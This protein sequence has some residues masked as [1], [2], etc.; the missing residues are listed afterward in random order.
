MSARDILNIKQDTRKVKDKLLELLQR[1]EQEGQQKLTREDP[2]MQLQRNYAQAAELENYRRAQASAAK[3]VGQAMEEL[4][5]NPLYMN[6]LRDIQQKRN[7]RIAREYGNDLGMQQAAQGAVRAA[8]PVLGD[9]RRQHAEDIINR[10]ATWKSQISGT[11]QPPRGSTMT[12]AEQ[13]EAKR[14]AQ[15]IADKTGMTPWFQDPEN[16]TEAEMKAYSLASTAATSDW[17]RNHP[18]AGKARGAA[19]RLDNDLAAENAFRTVKGK[20]QTLQDRQDQDEFEADQAF[21]WWMQ[22]EDGQRMLPY[23]GG[24]EA[25]LRQAYNAD[26]HQAGAGQGIKT[27]AV[28]MWKKALQEQKRQEKAAATAKVGGSP[29]VEWTNT[30]EGQALAGEYRQRVQDYSADMLMEAWDYLDP[31]DRESYYAYIH[32]GQPRDLSLVLGEDYHEMKDEEAAAFREELVDASLMRDF[33]DKYGRNGD[34]YYA[35]RENQE[36]GDR[37]AQE[38]IGK[39]QGYGAQVMNQVY[40]TSAENPLG[41]W[42]LWNQEFERVE[43]NLAE[44][45]TMKAAGAYADDPYYSVNWNEN[46][47]DQITILENVQALM[48][49]S[50]VVMEPDFAMRSQPI[51]D[52]E[53]DSTYAMIAGWIQPPTEEEETVEDSDDWTYEDERSR[54]LT[55]KA[56]TMGDYVD[57]M[58]SGERSTYFYI[59]NTQGKEAALEY[60]YALENEMLYKS[61]SARRERE[62]QWAK[63]NPWLSSVTDILMTPARG[64]SAASYMIGNLASGGH[65]SPYHHSLDIADN[66]VQHRRA[67]DDLTWVQAG[68][69]AKGW[70]GDAFI[71]ANQAWRSMTGGPELTE[72]D[73]ARIREGIQQGLLDLKHGGDSGGD[74]A[75]TMAA[76]IGMGKLLGACMTG[77][78]CG[79]SAL[80]MTAEEFTRWTFSAGMQMSLWWQSAQA[81]ALSTANAKETG[82][83]DRVAAIRGIADFAA[84]HLTET[85]G[86]EGLARYGILNTALRGRGHFMAANFVLSCVAEG[87]E[88]VGSGLF[89]M[90]LDRALNRSAAEWDRDRWAYYQ[91]HQDE[92]I[93]LE[94]ADIAVGAKFAGE[95]ATEAIITAITTGPATAGNMMMNRIGIQQQAQQSVNNM[96]TQGLLT[97]SQVKSATQTL[98]R[99]MTAE[100]NI[101]MAQEEGIAP[102]AEDLE[103]LQARETLLGTI[104]DNQLDQLGSEAFAAMELE[105]A[106]ETGKTGT[107]AQTEAT[108][109][110]AEKGAED[111]E[112]AKIRQ[113]REENQEHLEKARKDLD[114]AQKK[115]DEAQNGQNSDMKTG[116][117][118]VLTNDTEE[119]IKADISRL[120]YQVRQFEQR[121]QML[122]QQEADLQKQGAE[123]GT[124]GFQPEGTRKQGADN[125]QQKAVRSRED[126]QQEM[127]QLQQGIEQAKAKQEEM[128]AIIATTEDESALS[129]A[130]DLMAEQQ[131]IEHAMQQ[132]Q[133]ELKEE[134]AQAEEAER[135]EAEEKETKEKETEKQQADTDIGQ[136]LHREARQELPKFTEEEVQNVYRILH[137]RQTK[138]EM[139]QDE[140]RELMEKWAEYRNAQGHMVLDARVK[141]DGHDAKVVGLESV[142]EDAQVIVEQDGERSTMALDDE[143]LKFS[144][145]WQRE[146]YQFA[147]GMKDLTA[148][149]LVLGA[150]EKSEAEFYTFQRAFSEVYDAARNGMQLNQAQKVLA[151]TLGA[152]LTN[153][154][155]QVGYETMQAE[156]QKLLGSKN[157]QDMRAYLRAMRNRDT[158]AEGYKGAVLGQT[159]QIDNL[160]ADQMISIQI[161]DTLAQNIGLRI[162]I[163][164]HIQTKA[165]QMKVEETE[166]KQVPVR[167]GV[168]NGE[169]IKGSN[170]MLVALDSMEGAIVNHA[171]HESWHWVRDQAKKQ[172]DK[173]LQAEVDAFGYQVLER[174]KKNDPAYNV[175]DRIRE[176]IEQYASMGVELTRGEAEEELQA[177]A[178]MALMNDITEMELMQEQ[179]P[180]ILKKI[181]DGLKYWARK[182]RD[183]IKGIGWDNTEVRTMLATEADQLEAMARK[184]YDLM[185]L[186]GQNQKLQPGKNARAYSLSNEAAQEPVMYSMAGVQAQGKFGEAA[187]MANEMARQGRTD[188]EIRKATGAIKGYRGRWWARIDNTDMR[189][190][191]DTLLRNAILRAVENNGMLGVAL[192]DLYEAEDLYQAYPQLRDTQVTFREMQE[193]ALAAV[194]FVNGRAYIEI[195]TEEIR[196]LEDQGENFATL[197]EESLQHEVQHIIQHYEGSNEGSNTVIW[198]RIRQA[199]R[200]TAEQMNRD[201]MTL[202]DAYGDDFMSDIHLTPRYRLDEGSYT[203]AELEEIQQTIPAE[204][205]QAWGDIRRF[206]DKY[207]RIMNEDA[208]TLYRNTVGEIEARSQE[209]RGSKLNPDY[210]NAVAVEDYV[211]LET[212]EVRYSVSDADYMDAVRRG[213]TLKAADMVAEAARRAGY[214]LRVFHQTKAEFNRFNTDNESAGQYDDETPT[215]LFFKTTPEDI[216]LDGKKQMGLFIRSSRMI[217]FANREEIRKYWDEHVPGYKELR[218]KMD[219]EDRRLEQEYKEIDARWD[220]YY[221]EHYDAFVANDPTVTTELHQITKELDA[222][223]EKWE[224]DLHPIR[225]QLKEMINSY[226]RTADFDGIHLAFDGKMPG[227]PAVETYIVFDPSQVKS[228][229]PVTYDDDGN[230]IP[231]SERFNPE[232]DDIRYSLAKGKTATREETERA[233]KI[234]QSAAARSTGMQVDA[235]TRSAYTDMRLSLTTL[236]K[237]EYVTNRNK[238][239]QMVMEATSRDLE[240]VSKWFDDV[241]GIASMIAADRTRLD[242]VGLRN[243]EGELVNS[244]LKSNP[245][246]GGSIDMSLI[247]AKRRL[248]TGTIDA[249]QRRLGDSGFLTAEEMMQVRNMLLKKGYQAACGLCFVE[250][251]RKNMG[252]LMNDFRNAY[253]EKHKGDGAF[254]PSMTDINTVDGLADLEI[255]HPDVYWELVAYMN[256]MAQRKPK[257]YEVRTEYNN[258]ILKRFS[259]DGTVEAKNLA[260]GLRINSFSDFEVVHL[261]D[262]MQVIMDMSAVGLA[263]QAYTKVPDFAWALGGTGL[264]INLSMIAKG[265][266]RDGKIIFDEVEGMKA[267]D[268]FDLR[269]EY[270]DNVGTILVVFTDAQLRAAVNDDRI[271]FIIPFHRSQWKKADYPN[272]GLAKDTR[273]YTMHQNERWLHPSRHLNANGNKTRP[274]NFMPNE[275]W[276]FSLSGKENAK[277]YLQKCAEEDRRPKF[278]K[279][280]VDNHNGTW[281]LPEDGSMDGYWKLLIDFKMYNNKGEGRRQMPVQ[282]IFNMEQCERMLRD[283]KGGHDTFPVADDVVD[284]FMAQREKER[285]KRKAAQE[286]ASYSL[287]SPVEYSL[288]GIDETDPGMAQL[289]SENERFRNLTAQLAAELNRQEQRSTAQLTSMANMNRLAR[290]LRDKWRVAL[291]I[292]TMAENLRKIFEGLSQARTVAQAQAAMQA[293]GDFARDAILN[294]QTTDRTAHDQYSEARGL[295]RRN[296]RADRATILDVFGDMSSY[297]KN[298]FGRVKLVNQGMNV[299]SLYT[300][301]RDNYPGTLPDGLVNEADQLRAMLD[302]L[303]ATDIR[304]YNPYEEGDEA[305]MGGTVEVVSREL[306]MRLL[307]MYAEGGKDA[308][309]NGMSTHRMDQINGLLDRAEVVVQDTNRTMTTAGYRG[310]TSREYNQRI[311]D[312]RRELQQRGEAVQQRNATILQLETELKEA[313]RQIRDG[314]STIQTLRTRLN[315]QQAALNSQQVEDLKNQIRQEEAKV[316]A[317]QRAAQALQNR[318]DRSRQTQELNKIKRE[319]MR[320]KASLLKKLNSP[321][322]NGWIPLDMEDAVR[323]LLT[324]VDTEGDISGTPNAPLTAAALQK[325]K[326]AYESINKPAA[327]GQP[328]GPMWAYYNGDLA[329]TFDDLARTADG[330]RVRDL[331]QKELEQL[332]DIVAGYAAAVINEDRMF[333]QARSDSLRQMGG[334]MIQQTQD[335]ISTMGEVRV[336]GP[337]ASWISQATDRGLLK[338]VTVFER[339]NGTV[340]GDIWRNALRPAEWQHIRNI[341]QAEKF[342]NDALDTYHQH[343]SLNADGS[344]KQ[345]RTAFT[346]SS[347]RTIHLT[348]QELMTLYA[349]QQ[350]EK[351]VGTNHLLGGGVKLANPQRGDTLEEYRLTAG[352]LQQFNA[353]LNQEQK[354]YVDHMV[355]YLSTTVGEWGNAVTRELYGIEKFRETYY[356]PFTVA[357]SYVAQQPATQQDQRIKTASFT[358]ALTDKATTTLELRGF[359][360]LWSSHVEQMSDFNAFTLPMEDVVRLMNYKEGA[361]DD[362]GNFIGQGD[363]VRP[364]MER[365]WGKNT[366]GYIH[367]FLSRLNG[368]SRNEAGGSWLNT[369]MGRA[370]GAAVTWNL[371][372]AFQQA[373]AGVRAMAEMDPRDVLP[374]IIT[375]IWQNRWFTNNYRELMKY[376]P[377]AVEKSWGYFDTNM[378]RGLY[379]RA[380]T[381][382]RSRLD[383]AGGWLAGKGDELNWSQIWA[384]CKHEIR[385]LNPNMTEEEVKEHAAERFVEVID[386]TQVVDSIFQRSAFATEKG[387]MRGLM[388]FMSEPVTMYNMVVRAVDQYRDAIRSKDQTARRAARVKAIQTTCSITLSAALTAFLKSMATGLRDR[389]PEKKDED[390][391][392]IGSPSYMDKVLSAWA[393]NFAENLM[394]LTTIFGNLYD[395]AVSNYGNSDLTTAWIS[396]IYNAGKEILKG[397][398]ADW[399]KVAY[400]STQALSNLTGI[401]FAGLYRDTKA[402][403]MTVRELMDPESLSGTAWDKS[404]PWDVRLRAAERNYSYNKQKG[405]DYYN[406]ALLEEY[407]AH[408]FSEDFQKIADSA[409]R[410]GANEGTLMSGFKTKLKKVEPRIQQAA[411]ALANGDLETYERLMGELTQSGIGMKTASSLVN[412]AYN[413]MVKPEQEE[414]DPG[415]GAG[416]V[417]AL[418]AEGSSTTAPAKNAGDDLLT[419]KTSTEDVQRAVQMYKAAGMTQDKITDKVSGK[420]KRPYIMAV[421]QG[422]KAES[423]RLAGNLKAGGITQDQMKSWTTDGVLSS[424][425]GYGLYW[426]IKEGRTDDAKKTVQYLNKNFPGGQAAVKKRLLNWAKGL[427]PGS[428]DYATVKRVLLALGFAEST[429]NSTLKK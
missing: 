116:S 173:T 250:S 313:Q 10:W 118:V 125:E 95:L 301:I 194:D 404:K 148:A 285:G 365:A 311:N 425:Q 316:R 263:G 380:Q 195:N 242:Y 143:S 109:Q 51:R 53:G 128:A 86:A 21:D 320:R 391:N 111:Q 300:E 384:A 181:V 71:G 322:R 66:T 110:Q 343:E 401:G 136:E 23:F 198:E 60:L 85:I 345:Q 297:R 188:E 255:Q 227:Y 41:A 18:N 222:F 243:A 414:E 169:F 7:K 156:S 328:A 219:A 133:E 11:W 304:S 346:L 228:A 305:R 357:Q 339:F 140:K 233:E 192:E 426:M 276:D 37:A 67:T 327:N 389:T 180:S 102:R 337:L 81:G 330:K 298:G 420:Y 299:D 323:E 105:R 419:D 201:M 363:N 350:R 39:W 170:T 231:L 352:D 106:D 223:L 4:H 366:V 127:Q 78:G 387:M 257:M 251:S 157:I 215:G 342:L 258:E 82:A 326:A 224:N 374:S 72:E 149:R 100:Q 73:K 151:R 340:L 209:E 422:D 179:H 161:L 122:A 407:M 50:A 189:Y 182:I 229:R 27:R 392:I 175:E 203:Q 76:G 332:R 271:D 47:D 312:L 293:L 213:D 241:M 87:L 291:P 234:N 63:E 261:I 331:S 137:G 310:M 302:F 114:M 88:E 40:E 405:K 325:A 99:A 427:K 398:D 341:Q 245:E 158:A 22:T 183:A 367:D 117:R 416:L 132:R 359:T 83:S 217:E 45:R 107:E 2:L 56:A 134:L 154:I 42:M 266:G 61:A 395:N 306:A 112:L 372:V 225:R 75:F 262:M 19:M 3:P 421:L 259:N 69:A 226:V 275:Y 368:N 54:V 348:D 358:K 144:N 64:M 120:G 119:K 386:R 38:R 74:S 256:K 235:G 6:H 142:G 260:G 14:R 360:E 9:Q 28:G 378:N 178:I 31:E 371:S 68:Y 294:A 370:K 412:T 210:R 124:S 30:E 139:T 58:T 364:L 220:A 97:Q 150:W 314:Q 171:G 424:T 267:K 246:Y 146:V 406:G 321:N 239:I 155:R 16:P 410:M 147:R 318:I 8:A 356:L 385:R 196:K 141:V 281:S 403:F 129:V 317:A 272:L 218:Q 252:K 377:I 290:E 280:L 429:I 369:M 13:A 77:T 5:Q 1:S 206:W 394:G 80:G 237:S 288:N 274:R 333:T 214:D 15:G 93:S 131:K 187:R 104:E 383:D 336:S 193:D 70:L 176:K 349:W 381:T 207:A 202:Y 287:S 172:G 238:M 52:Y 329:Q 35:E 138:T 335:R 265:V 48:A 29:F 46:I 62:Y 162:V 153:R 296:L 283:Y 264:K 25:A 33:N 98:A 165:E 191:P 96:V 282:P 428:Y 415:T 338:P 205:I 103:A 174:M 376:A 254:I 319:I 204:D 121:D 270:S 34:R 55:G 184:Y 57:H 130:S 344:R 49:M 177:D 190:N 307:R 248:M 43:Q 399:D 197:I 308:A 32:K 393:P 402:I 355:E 295:I 79:A 247:C 324:A 91:E 354:D 232:K 269:N 167:A 278:A 408:G 84:E 273:D 334:E 413:A 353:A 423:T 160:S 236:N 89:S 216:G 44:L 315:N 396:N 126:I 347:G 351:L 208:R 164:P 379:Q 418:Q 230:V 113:A 279:Y 36:L 390:G 94:Q 382:F 373:G 145:R 24:S 284:E 12:K 400:R 101:Q 397:A 185:K 409:I 168:V 108:E 309:V 199:Y 92:G 361:Y 221:D 17:Y 90:A 59:Y 135:R 253:M 20:A 152:T 286:G 303:D 292:K 375:G 200:Q 411:Q 26:Y 362:Q 211:D 417:E 240:T 388:S 244:A 186:V 249:I 115:L 123:Q 159:I 212:G 163:V 268:A 277:R 166:G 65:Y 289:L